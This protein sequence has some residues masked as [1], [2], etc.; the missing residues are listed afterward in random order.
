[1][2]LTEHLTEN[3]LS[4]Y[5]GDALEDK[6]RREIGRHLLVCDFCLKRLPQPT[7]EQFWKALMTENDV[8]DRVEETTDFLPRLGFV[9]RLFTPPKMLAWS[10]GGLAIVLFFIVLIGFN[11]KKPLNEEREVAQVFDSEIAELKQNEKDKENI[12]LSVMTPKPNDRASLPEPSRVVVFSEPTKLDSQKRSRSLSNEN[13]LRRNSKKT[14]LNENEEKISSTRGVSAAKCGEKDSI[15]MEIDANNDKALVFRWAKVPNAAKYHLYISDEEEILIDEY[16]TERESEYILRK[17]LDPLKTY[18]WKVV[19]TLDDGQTASG[20]SQKFTV[21]DVLQDQKKL[22][23]KK[24][25]GIRC[26]ENK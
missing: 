26:S 15:E 21:K 7:P 20:D 13:N 9:T 11:V 2:N 14:I 1:M 24:K 6:K 18:K 25:S 16:E 12:P 5:F 23:G 3:Q 4:D 8:N 19:V 22:T 17:T 10:A